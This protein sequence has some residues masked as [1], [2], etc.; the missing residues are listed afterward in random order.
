M[1]ASAMRR[2]IRLALVTSR[3]CP[4]H[5]AS[6]RHATCLSMAVADAATYAAQR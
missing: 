2:V 1:I 6:F 5:A 4:V 3:W